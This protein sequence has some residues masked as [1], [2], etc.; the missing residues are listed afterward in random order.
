MSGNSG[1]Y[2]VSYVTK[3]YACSPCGTWRHR[4][5]P[6]GLAGWGGAG[7]VRGRRLLRGA[8]HHNRPPWWHR[9]SLSR[10][11][12]LRPENVHCR[13]DW[14]PT[15]ETKNC[16]WFWTTSSRYSCRTAV[17]SCSQSQARG[18]GHQ[19]QRAEGLRSKSS[20][21]HLGATPPRTP[22]CY[23]QAKPVRGGAA[24]HRRQGCQVRLLGDRRERPRGG[25]DLHAVGR[26]ALA[27]ELAAARIKLLP[28]RAMLERLGSRLK[29]VTGER[30]ICQSASGP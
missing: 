9:P 11:G 7:R 12:S 17:G 1:K 20:R 21:C 18:P 27:I 5:D 23:R 26:I 10:S 8:G 15:F 4:Q 30:A 16:C 6:P 14:K 24:L 22:A 29:L 19:S 28:P 2:A 13:R 25:R 3:R